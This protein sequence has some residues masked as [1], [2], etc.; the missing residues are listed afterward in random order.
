MRRVRFLILLLLAVSLVATVAPVEAQSK[1]L[2]WEQFDVFLNVLPNGD[3]RVTERQTIQFTS[4]TFTFGF[5]VIPL[6]KTEGIVDIS[7]S[8]PD[9]GRV[10]NQTDYSI[11]PYTFWTSQTG[12]ELE[13]RWYF[14]PTTN[15]IRTFDLSYTVKGA[16]RIYEAGDKLQWIAID[17]ER[18]FPIRDSV[19]QVTLPEGAS[20]LDIDSAGVRADWQ[21]S[22]DGRSVRYV[23]Q[24]S[25]SPSQTFEIGV[26][27]THG[28]IPAEQPD[29]QPA[30]DRETYFDQN[31][32]PILNL[33]VGALALLMA[34]G[35]PV[36]VYLLWYMRGRDPVV[37]PVPE[38]ISQKP[39]DLQPGLLG[40]LID[41]KADMQDIVATIVDLARRGYMTIE[42]KEEK[43]FFGL[44]STDFVYHRTSKPDSDLLDYEKR[45]L[46]GVFG[47]SR[48]RRELSDL[49]NKFYKHLPKIQNALY[50]ELVDQ[51]LFKRRPDRTRGLWTGLGIAG[52]VLAFVGGIFL[53]PLA[54]YSF[55]F[56]CLAFSLGIGAVSLLIASRFMPA[57][58]VKGS[59]SAAKWDAFRNYLRELKDLEEL[60]NAAEIFEKYLPYAIAFGMN[61]SF[62]NKFA[63]VTDAPAPGWY[64]PLPR[65]GLATSGG[66]RGLATDVGS[67]AGMGQGGLQSMSEGM[68]G[69]LQSMS[70]GLTSMLNSAGRVMRSAPSSS[71]SSGGSFG[72]GGFSGGGFSGG[73]GGGGGG[74]GFG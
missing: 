68:S 42:E 73:G 70:D 63:R 71:G 41:E 9:Q 67:G 5:A 12:D 36:L 43:G 39:D 2:V 3:L 17:N 69:G 32:R 33:A 52:I 21:Q 65:R 30:F 25:L 51:D 40:S 27:F 49:R 54:E 13:I 11:D 6:D 50:D 23:A 64:V 35:G 4:G 28:M 61:N 66:G 60:D 18:D 16:V 48:K 7:V 1:T 31:V 56:P 55:A 24:D 58:T 10:Y 8:E 72:G 57:K 37:G 19:V 26:E 62:V 46:R 15:N 53:T 47:S 14:P 38:Q 74:R 22:E 20:F 34:I 59:E 29:W 45:I 44:G